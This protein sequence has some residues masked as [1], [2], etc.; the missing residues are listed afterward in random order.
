MVQNVRSFSNTQKRI[1]PYL[2]LNHSHR[3]LQEKNKEKKHDAYMKQEVKEHQ[4]FL[5]IKISQ[6]SLI[7]AEAVTVSPCV[8]STDHFHKRQRHQ[9]TVT[10][11]FKDE[12]RGGNQSNDDFSL[13]WW[14]S[15][16]SSST[17][18]SGGSSAVVSSTKAGH[19]LYCSTQLAHSVKS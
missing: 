7:R 9:T 19:L 14:E 15:W 12:L 11:P 8:S 2:K 13:G 17:T 18:S 16:Y 5:R 1:N 4:F 10:Q 6:F 3:L